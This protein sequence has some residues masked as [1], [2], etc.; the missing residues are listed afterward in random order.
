MIFRYFPP[1][2]VQFDKIVRSPT[3]SGDQMQRSPEPTDRRSRRVRGEIAALLVDGVAWPIGMVAAVWTRYGFAMSPE[4]LSGA[5]LMA[6]VAAVIQAL[7]TQA[8]QLRYGRHG[9]AT[10]ED[11]R[12]VSVT[13]LSA[14]AVLVPLDLLVTP[15]P[16]PASCTLVGALLALLVM[17][18]VRYLYR[19]FE[20]HT[21]RPRHSAAPTLI[22]GAGSTGQALA[23][24]LLRDP[25]G[26]YLPVGLVDDDAGKRQL[27]FNG[28]PVLGGRLDIPAIVRKTGATTVVFAIAHADAELIRETQTIA[29]S[30]GATFKVV[31]SV[32]ELL[33]G[34]VGAADVR[35]LEPADLLGRRQVDLDLENIAGYLTG[36]RVL[37]TGAGGSIGS[38]LCRQI[39]RFAP[40]ELMMLDRDESALHA[41]QLSLNG[42]ALLDGTDLILADLRDADAIR[43]VFATRKPQVVFHAA[44]LKH[45][46]LLEKHPAEALKTNIRGTQTLLELARDVERFVNISTDKAANPTSVLGYS[47]RVT[48]RLTA[49][50]ARE[51][52][53]TFLSVRF[54]NVLGS[55]GSV[56]TAFTAQAANGGPITVT[57]PEVTRFF[58]TVQEA[59]Q[60]VI[61][62]AAIGR[63]GEVLV[64][65]MGKPV[66]ILDV[67]RQL[68]SQAPRPVEIVYTGLR[69]GEKLHEELFGADEHDERPLHPLVSHVDTPP[70]DPGVIERLEAE[71][72]PARLV[73]ALAT[74]TDVTAGRVPQAR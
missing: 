11:V 67:A 52:A 15:R 26:G 73:T 12:A 59:V 74:L 7:V 28:L 35:D 60:L 2:T 3:E 70:L 18:T 63:G 29:L 53:G 50:A 44:A 39:Q 58:M 54:G 10:F 13:V 68:A 64:L 17:Q 16:V 31:P 49:H 6:A 8:W 19:Q 30:A 5:I 22:V 9:Y 32:G 72:D 38:E 37:V 45:L 62:A 1:K 55:R 69:P 21:A 40:A 41:V 34:R 66:R 48:E 23:R 65:D 57:H 56:L 25:R 27:R 47:K 14:A 51:Y 42:R 4:A 46:P 71:T 33:D 36:K 20:D 61:Q 43:E 24:S